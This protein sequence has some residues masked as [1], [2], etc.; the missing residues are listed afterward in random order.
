MFKP[1][2]VVT[3]INETSGSRGVLTVGN[4]YT[5]TLCKDDDTWIIGFEHSWRTHNF[6][7]SKESKIRKILD[8]V[9]RESIHFPE[10]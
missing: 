3:R 2:D 7:L 5:V 9:D 1:G 6:I 4:Q 8:K 10:T